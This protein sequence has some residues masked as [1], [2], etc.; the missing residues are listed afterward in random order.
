MF[1]KAQ[2]CLLRRSLFFFRLSI[3]FQARLLL[4][5]FI[6]A[7]DFFNSNYSPPPH[8]RLPLA[9]VIKPRRPRPSPHRRRRFRAPEPPGPSV[10]PII[11]GKGTITLASP[12]PLIQNPKRSSSA[13]VNVSDPDSS[14][15]QLKFSR[16]FAFPSQYKLGVASRL[17]S[18]SC[19]CRHPL[20]SLS[21]TLSQ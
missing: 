4:S 5:Y 3:F 17:K 11:N 21:R 9:P 14:I 6:F 12:K 1:E 15:Q 8:C 10:L 16:L 2:R 19:D 20:L 13:E 18:S 7:G